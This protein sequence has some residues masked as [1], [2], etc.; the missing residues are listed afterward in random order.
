MGIPSGSHHI[1]KKCREFRRAAKDKTDTAYDFLGSRKDWKKISDSVWE[2]FQNDWLPNCNYVT[3]IPAK[4]NM[5]PFSPRHLI[6][7][8]SLNTEAVASLSW[9]GGVFVVNSEL[10][11]AA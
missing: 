5:P 10:I 1:L 8:G 7:I 2:N 9:N 3:N 4:N 11:T 6:Y